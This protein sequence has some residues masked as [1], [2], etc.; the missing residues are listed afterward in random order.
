MIQ[1]TVNGYISFLYRSC[2]NCLA[3]YRSY[4]TNDE[5]LLIS[6]QSK[7]KKCSCTKK[8]YDLIIINDAKFDSTN[9]KRLTVN[10]HMLYCTNYLKLYKYYINNDEG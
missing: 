2:T 1:L 10:Y 7:H 6:H 9:N 5:A 8:K 3:L 4:V